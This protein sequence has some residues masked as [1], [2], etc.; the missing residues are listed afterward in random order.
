MASWALHHLCH[1]LVAKLSHHLQPVP[2][3]KLPLIE[4]ELHAFL[5]MHDLRNFVTFGVELNRTRLIRIEGVLVMVPQPLQG[6]IV[7]ELG[8]G[9]ECC[10]SLEEAQV[11]ETGGR[12]HHLMQIQRSV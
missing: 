5:R 10:I 12:N 6:G 8:L 3:P 9:G 7:I 2:K 1:I 4:L 11:L